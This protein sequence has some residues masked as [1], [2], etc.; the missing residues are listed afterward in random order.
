M[1]TK[2]IFDY[3]KEKFSDKILE[4]KEIKIDSFITITSDSVAEVLGFLKNDEKLKF[5]YLMCIS[6]VDLSTYMDPQTKAKGPD[7]FNIVY[8]LFSY[9]HKNSVVIKTELP[10]E[11]AEVHTISNI[12]K[13]A[14]WYEREVYDMFGIKFTNHP[15]LRRILCPDD[16]EGYPLRKD[17]VTAETYIGVRIIR[18]KYER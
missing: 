4:C 7:K 6:G 5:D 14:D 10:R 13:T 11:N 3:L 1:T 9:N 12:W 17:Y 16:W 2:E 15:D 8:H 18:T